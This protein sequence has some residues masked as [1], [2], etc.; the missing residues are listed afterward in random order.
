MEATLLVGVV[1]S[2]VELVRPVAPAAIDDHHDLFAGVAEDGHH[3]MHLWPQLLGSTMRHN[4]IEDFGS[5]LW[6]RP[7]DTEQHPVGDTA[8]GAIASP[9]WAC[10]GLLTGDLPL[11]QGTYREADTLGGA[12]PARAGEGKAP[13]ARCVCI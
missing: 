10:E 12:P 6:D 11:A 8:P 5:T 7:N 9:R 4:C 2:R 13:Q 1:E 3:L